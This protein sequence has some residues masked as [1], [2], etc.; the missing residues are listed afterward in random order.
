MEI[1]SEIT[2][3]LLRDSKNKGF[4]STLVVFNSD[5]MTSLKMFSLKLLRIKEFCDSVYLSALIVSTS[6]IS[7]R[8]FVTVGL[9][10][11]PPEPPDGMA[12]DRL[13]PP[14]LKISIPV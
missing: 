3:F 7:C 5:S 12:D 14:L 6:S 4:K 2:P 11:T 13:S 1:S 8:S 10:L 9:P